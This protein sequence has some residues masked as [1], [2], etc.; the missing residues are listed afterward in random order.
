M[1]TVEAKQREGDTVW[2]SLTTEEVKAKVL[3]ESEERKKL[4]EVQKHHVKDLLKKPNV[5]SVDIDYKRINGKE[6]DQLAIVIGVRK[7]K[8][9]SQLNKDEILPK[10]L[11]DCVVD[12]IE[13]VA[14]YAKKPSKLGRT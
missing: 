3:S 8:P 10:K 1:M 9:E 11:D 6:V 4:K 12:V 13:Q 5:T 2:S 7:K 14:T